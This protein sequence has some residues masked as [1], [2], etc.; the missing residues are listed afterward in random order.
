MVLKQKIGA[1]AAGIPAGL[2]LGLLVSGIV[3]FGGAALVAKLIESE[4]I[5]ENGVGYDAMIV[6]VIASAMG[7]WTAEGRIQRMRLQVCL[8]SG[9]SYFLALL[10][11]TA[12]FFGGQY[13]GMGVTA[14]A[15]L[16]GS[17]GVA[18]L[19]MRPQKNRIRHGRKKAYR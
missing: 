4:K 7:A 12:L 3:T 17:A 6:L 5:G 2:A 19:S 11:A 13:S 14:L 16:A 10:S 8:L 1:R 18:L 9:L 15:I